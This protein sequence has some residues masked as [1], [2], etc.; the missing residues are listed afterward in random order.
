MRDEAVRRER[1]GILRDALAIGLTTGGY[2]I[3]FGA[4]GV[5][6]GLSVL[7]TCLLSLLMFT[8][9]SQFA[10]VGVLANGGS[11]LSAAATAALVGSRNA[12][13][14][15]RMAPLL[16]VRGM[17]RA[18]SA[19]LVI[20]ESTAM[21]VARDG[22]PPQGRFAFFAT[23]LSIFAC[24]N[25]G[26]LAGALGGQALGDPETY[27]LDVA[28]TAAFVALLWPQARDRTTRAAALVAA[29]VA[30]CVVPLL[31]TG[32]PVMV[33]ALVAVAIA[34]GRDRRRR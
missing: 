30:L 20:D 5:T 28:A 7:Q 34:L 22:D 24:W 16:A 32:A 1:R 12:L 6:T 14:A 8:G 33:G 9:A 29:A 23:G 4:L 13:Y 11:A 26:T 18:L 19:H 31:P 2:A 17:R 27:G 10:L 25:L 3:S 15:L 21:A